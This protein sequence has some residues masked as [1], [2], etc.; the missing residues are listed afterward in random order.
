MV[1]LTWEQ[2]PYGSAYDHA[3]NGVVG[4]SKIAHDQRYSHGKGK[5]QKSEFF[6][7]RLVYQLVRAL[8][9]EAQNDADADKARTAV[10]HPEPQCYERKGEEKEDRGAE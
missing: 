5:Y 6:K 8:Y 4:V 2:Q 3:E 7:A 10:L 9:Q 1:D